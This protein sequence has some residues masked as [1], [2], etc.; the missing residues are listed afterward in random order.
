MVIAHILGCGSVGTHFAHNLVATLDIKE[1]FLY[2]FDTIEA[3]NIGH[4]I[5]LASSIGRPKV[6][7]LKEDLILNFRDRID[8]L[9]IHAEN[10]KVTGGLNVGR[11][12][13]IVDCFDNPESRAVSQLSATAHLLHIGFS[14]DQTGLVHWDEGYV[15]PQGPIMEDPC[16]RPGFYAFVSLLSSVGVLSVVEMLEG[17]KN[18]YLVYGK[19]VKKL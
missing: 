19:Q 7:V 17:T 5:R 8:P 2:D 1:L 4:R 13:L 3:R 10:E 16:D 14:P 18:N 12:E 15:V 6:N 11:D 9:K